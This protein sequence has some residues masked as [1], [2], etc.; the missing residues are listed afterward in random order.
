MSGSPFSFSEFVAATV[1]DDRS[2]ST[3]G[4][5]DVVLDIPIATEDDEDVR[6]DIPIISDIEDS[7]S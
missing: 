1:E 6:L 5:E 3:L 4:T 2:V 7:T